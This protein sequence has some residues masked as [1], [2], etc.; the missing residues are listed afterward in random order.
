MAQEQ[1]R[2]ELDGKVIPI[3]GEVVSEIAAAAAARASVSRR[4]RELSLL[5]GRALE[6]GQARLG[7]GDLRALVVV[8]EEEHPERFGPAVAELLQAVP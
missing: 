2:L 3:P 4:H 1:V 6:F 7:K 8:I 5:L